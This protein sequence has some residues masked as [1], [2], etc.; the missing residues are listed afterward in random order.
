MHAQEYSNKQ[1]GWIIIAAVGGAIVAMVVIS[2]FTKEFV[3]AIPVTAIIL[4]LTLINFSTLT[5]KVNE[6][7][8]SLHFGPGLIRKSFRLSEMMSSEVVTNPWYAGW[9]IRIGP[10]GW[11]FNVSG[12]RGIEIRMKSG[13]KYRIGSNEPEKLDSYIR[14]KLAGHS[15]VC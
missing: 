12:N 8:L 7:K 15:G 9:G 2:V 10:D 1:V 5:V 3:W 6:E 13:A 14:Q 4:L 11:L